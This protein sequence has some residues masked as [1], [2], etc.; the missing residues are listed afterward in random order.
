MAQRI[1]LRRATAAQWT[2]NNPILAIGEP[3][4]ET[5]TK[6]VKIGDGSTPWNSL[7]YAFSVIVLGDADETHKGLVEKATQ[8]EVVAGTSLGETGAQ[9][10]VGP[11]ELKAYRDLGESLATLAGST[12]TCNCLDKVESRHNYATITSNTSVIFANKGNSKLHSLTTAI[13]GAN[14]VLTFESDT[15]MARYNETT[16]WNPTTKA[17]TV[18]STVAGDLHEFSLLKT[19]SVYILRY[20]GPV[21]P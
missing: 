11:A 7:G 15:R 17:L 16:I 3:G 4:V 6:K 12:L 21:R 18:S 14:I 13:T 20:D 9:L 8:A 1:Q 2:T 10:F 5:D 19:G